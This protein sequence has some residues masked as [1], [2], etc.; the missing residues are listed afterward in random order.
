MGVQSSRGFV[1]DVSDVGER[2][3]EVE[4]FDALRLAARQGT[5]RPVEREVTKT[6]LN[7]RVESPQKVVSN[8]ATDGSY[9]RPIPGR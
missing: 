8:G 6:D 5:R 3:A 7:E 2:G 4:N 1:E 9:P